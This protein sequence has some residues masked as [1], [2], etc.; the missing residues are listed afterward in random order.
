M[1]LATIM[2]RGRGGGILFFVK[3]KKKK[4]KEKKKKEIKG[5]EKDNQF[6]TC[7]IWKANATTHGCGGSS[8]SS[9]SRRP[10]YI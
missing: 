5:E 1:A 10:G 2:K 3:K 9:T 6:V 8:S 7:P 4:K